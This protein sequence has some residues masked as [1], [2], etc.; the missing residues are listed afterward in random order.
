MNRT[1][2]ALPFQ[3]F[4]ILYACYVVYVISIFEYT[5]SLE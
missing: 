3:M 1:D 5:P 2:M 4:F